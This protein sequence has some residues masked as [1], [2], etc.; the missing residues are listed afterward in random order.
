MDG[1]IASD[2]D[3]G[4]PSETNDGERGYHFSMLA[5]HPLIRRLAEGLI[6]TIT[7]PTFSG[8]PALYVTT[9]MVSLT[10]KGI[11]P[12]RLPLCGQRKRG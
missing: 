3:A 4:L 8:E 12:P 1:G 9:L 7:L 2:K 11:A 6:S 5:P 10:N